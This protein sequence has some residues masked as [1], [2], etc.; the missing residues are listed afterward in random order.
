MHAAVGDAATGVPLPRDLRVRR[1]CHEPP[2]PP[3]HCTYM[4]PCRH[5]TLAP[6]S[7]RDCPVQ[8]VTQPVASRGPVLWIAGERGVPLAC[9]GVVWL[10]SA[11]RSTAH[12][13]AIDALRWRFYAERYQPPSARKARTRS[14]VCVCA[15][16]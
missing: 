10:P 7:L 1:Q 4:S 2:L 3:A 8:G 14:A 13:S 5:S 15:G 11:C 12:Q 9:R 16:S 6:S